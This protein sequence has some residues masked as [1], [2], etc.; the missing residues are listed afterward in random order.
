MQHNEDHVSVLQCG[1]QV[2]PVQLANRLVVDL[3]TCGSCPNNAVSPDSSQHYTILCMGL[4]HLGQYGQSKLPNEVQLMLGEYEATHKIDTYSIRIP[5]KR[6]KGHGDHKQWILNN[7]AKLQQ[8]MQ[9]DEDEQMAEQMA[10]MPSDGGTISSA[11]S[12][13]EPDNKKPRIM[14]LDP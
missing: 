4:A 7:A 13:V 11:A 3:W 2:R 9:Q 10:S 8:E 5:P 6:H 12:V 1:G 14:N